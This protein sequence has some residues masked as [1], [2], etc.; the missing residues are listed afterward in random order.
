MNVSLCFF[1]DVLGASPALNNSLDAEHIFLLLD[2]IELGASFEV[3][4]KTTRFF[5]VAVEHC[6]VGGE[7]AVVFA[8]GI[9]LNDKFLVDPASDFV[10]DIVPLLGGILTDDVDVRTSRHRT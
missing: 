4:Y 1:G 8:V 9:V 5:A 3:A 10:K 7:L 6:A 2:D